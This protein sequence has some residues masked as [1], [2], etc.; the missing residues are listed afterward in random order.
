M[1]G[2]MHAE[3]KVPHIRISKDVFLR[4]VATFRTLALQSS[5]IPNCVTLQRS[6]YRFYCHVLQGALGIES[7]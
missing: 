7:A 6:I 5:Y 2:R 4:T 1:L 3:L